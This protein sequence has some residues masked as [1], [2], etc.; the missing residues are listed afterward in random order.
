MAQSHLIHPTFLES[1]FSFD[2]PVPVHVDKKPIVSFVPDAYGL[3]AVPLNM[4]GGEAIALDV[5]DLMMIT[6]L[7]RA[8]VQRQDLLVRT[9]G[10]M[11]NIFLMSPDDRRMACLYNGWGSPEA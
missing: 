7:V 9:R 10:V 5:P 4:I 2:G 6:A 11:E 1:N 8:R 3:Y